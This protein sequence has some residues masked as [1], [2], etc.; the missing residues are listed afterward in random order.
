MTFGGQTDAGAS[1][2]MLERFLDSEC[3][4][5]HPTDGRAE[6]DTARMYQHG[7]AE[8][9][10]PEEQGAAKRVLHETSLWECAGLCTGV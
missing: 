9:G 6:I 1:E 8:E 4:A 7:G 2:T 10:Q 5:R 3:A